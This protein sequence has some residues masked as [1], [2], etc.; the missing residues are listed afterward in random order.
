M[1]Y[2]HIDYITLRNQLASRLDDQSKVRWTDDEL[3]RYVCE[4]LRVWQAFAAYTRERTVFATVAGTSW[5]DLPTVLPAGI[6][7]YNVTDAELVYLMEYHLIEPPAIPWTGTA[8]FSL[9]DLTQ[10]LERRRNQ[11]LADSGMVVTRAVAPIAPPPDGRMPL[12]DTVIDVRRVGWKDAAGLTTPLWRTDEWAANS[13]QPGWAASP[14]RPRGYSVLAPPPLTLQLIPPP[15]DVGSIDLLGVHAGVALDP[16]VGV[17]LGIPDNF[18]W[19]VKW[20][21]LAEL[22][23]IEGE[24]KDK[25]RMVYCEQRYQDGVELARV[26][27]SVAQVTVGDVGVIGQAIAD[28]DAFNPNWQN[29]AGTVRDI[30]FAS[31][32]LLG[33]SRVPDDVYGISLDVIRN[34]ILP[35]NDA[36]KV[37]IGREI[38]TPILDYAQHLAMFKEG[39][40]EFIATGPL[41]ENFIRE[42]AIYNEKLRACSFYVRAIQQQTLRQAKLVPRRSSDA[43]I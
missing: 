30:G 6:L 11:F 14:G 22:L 1:P 26:S 3:K 7:D 9:A 17:L 23:A 37:Q 41:Y 34:A 42:A 28:W 31:Y 36:D 13:L 20:G 8:M 19:V 43:Q 5:Y 21:A 39:G 4:S 25:S 18:A 10:A 33:V 32:N 16:T 38:I 40:Q 24:A 27:P 35:V 15:N 2:N 12:V 29:V